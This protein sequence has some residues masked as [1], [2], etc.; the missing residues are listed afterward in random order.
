L[1][2]FITGVSCVGKTTIGAKLALLLNYP[3]FDLDQ[4]I[5]R[6]FGESIE[7]LKNRY[8]TVYSFRSQASKALYHLL[9]QEKSQD[10]VVALP[11]SGL[12]DCYWKVVKNSGAIVFVIKDKPINILNRITFY[13]IDSNPIQKNLSEME[14]QLYLQEI[15]EDIKYF[16]RSYHRA[17]MIIDINLLGPD[18]AARKIYE[19][20]GQI[21]LKGQAQ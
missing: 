19:L 6:Y 11:P 17:K 5:E 15:K 20:L 3:F 9:S 1:R 13:D 18:E 2:I 4:E 21:S 12:M 16:G 8:L 10:C 14:K 7:R